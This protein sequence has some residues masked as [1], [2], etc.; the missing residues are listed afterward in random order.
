MSSTPRIAEIDGLPALVVLTGGWRDEYREIIR[1]EGLAALSIRVNGEDLGFLDELRD[2]RGLVLNA[3]AVRDLAPIEALSNLETLTLNTPKRPR[4]DLDFASFSNLRRLGVY[5]NRGFE[6]L[7]S[8]SALEELYVFD[9]PDS[10]LVR[11]AELQSLRRLEL[12]QGRKL[13]STTGIDQLTQLT[14]LG[15]YHQSSLEALTDLGRAVSLRELAIE[16]C[17][18]LS[19]IDEISPLENLVTLKLANCGEIRSLQPLEGLRCLERLFAWES[20]KIVDGDLTVL[21]RLPRLREVAMMSRRA[22]NPT[23]QEVEALL[24]QRE[25]EPRVCRLDLPTDANE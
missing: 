11:F 7:A 25:F 14:F 23:V 5:W 4:L 13:I 17:K 21:T 19:V 20:T 2:L 3:W 9:P 15:L 24:A 8:S 1:K 18:K 10:D 12:S 6:S 22:Y 16:S